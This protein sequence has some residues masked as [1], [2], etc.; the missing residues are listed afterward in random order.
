MSLGLY[1][2]GTSSYFQLYIYVSSFSR[3]CH[4]KHCT[5]SLSFSTSFSKIPSSTSILPSS[6]SSSLGDVCLLHLQ[7]LVAGGNIRPSAHRHFCHHQDPQSQPKPDSDWG[8]RLHRPH[9]TH[10]PSGV[11]IAHLDSVPGHAVSQV[12]D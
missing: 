9:R 10:V 11:R 7:R 3:C 6:S 2:Y 1:S 8:V 12:T 5:T 4:P